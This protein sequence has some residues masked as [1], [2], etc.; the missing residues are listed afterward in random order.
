MTIRP[1]R[2]TSLVFWLLLVVW[3]TFHPALAQEQGLTLA[4]ALEHARKQAPTILAARDRIEEARGRLRA[5]SLR[6]RENPAIDVAAGK[7][8]TGETE[9]DLSFSQPFQMGGRRQARMAEAS[10]DVEREASASDNVARRLLQDVATAYLQSSASLRRVRI[11]MAGSQVSRALLLSMERRFELGDV[12]VLEVNLSKTA[13]ARARSDQR[14]AEADLVATLGDLRLLL[15]MTPQEP[16][17]IAGELPTGQD[18]D[19]AKLLQESENRPDLRVLAAELRQAEADV[20]LGKSFGWPEVAA[21]FSFEREESE[22]I[23]QATLSFSLPV[24]ARGQELR[25]TGSARA[26]RLRRQIDATRR[27]VQVEIRSAFDQYQTKLASAQELE[28][29]ALASLEEN[30]SL[31]QR[32]YEEGEIGLMELLLVRRNTLEIRTLHLNRLLDAAIGAVEVQ[33]RAGVLR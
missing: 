33:A 17:T 5:A 30:E 21:G 11:A 16:L 24:F 20:Q 4:Q 15:G 8:N 9:I 26:T 3:P 31:A 6:F 22:T 19:L 12:P 27:A 13:A 29:D 23:A 7:R 28:R 18:L 10:A 14:F 32:S 2:N 1:C 25:A